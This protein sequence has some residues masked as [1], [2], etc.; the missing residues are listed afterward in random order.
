MNEWMNEW[1]GK[2]YL[3]WYQSRS[4]GR[5]DNKM[6]K[7]KL[8]Q[9]YKDMEPADWPWIWVWNRE[10]DNCLI[11]VMCKTLELV[12]THPSWEAQFFK[13]AGYI[14][15]EII[16]MDGINVDLRCITGGWYLNWAID[17][18]WPS[19]KGLL[20]S[21]QGSANTED[22]TQPHCTLLDSIQ[23]LPTRIDRIL[24]SN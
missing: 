6:S 10:E 16:C 2:T 13:L 1:F 3:G 12:L 23:C 24:E 8:P 20:R 19:L 7:I 11:S 18:K 4:L 22:L 21:G 5:E 9:M 17:W 14:F 15:K